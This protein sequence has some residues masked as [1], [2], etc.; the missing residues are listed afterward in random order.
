MPFGVTALERAGAYLVW[1]RSAALNLNATFVGIT[2]QPFERPVQCRY[3]P[4]G[5]HNLFDLRRRPSRLVIVSTNPRDRFSG[6][7][8]SRV[9]CTPSALN[10]IA[11]EMLDVT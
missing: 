8:S 7:S 10:A 3:P 11:K 5:L 2:N 1:L 6:D 9:V 4:E